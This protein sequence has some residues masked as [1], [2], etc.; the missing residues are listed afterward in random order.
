MV[1]LNQ[2]D[3]Y[4]SKYS[5][6]SQILP[7]ILAPRRSMHLGLRNNKY[8]SSIFLNNPVEDK[9]VKQLMA[10]RKKQ[11]SFIHLYTLETLELAENKEIGL[12]CNKV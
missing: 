1:G 11:Y 9:A 12:K 7:P 6:I 4:F 2:F 8:L 10:E 5:D 3:Q